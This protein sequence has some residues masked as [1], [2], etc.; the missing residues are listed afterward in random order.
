MTSQGYPY[1]VSVGI[2][3]ITKLL[4]SRYQSWGLGVFDTIWG[5]ILKDIP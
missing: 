5:G 2:N 4:N 3:G 1:P